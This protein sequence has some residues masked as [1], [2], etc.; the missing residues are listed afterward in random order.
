MPCAGLDC[1]F[2]WTLGSRTAMV[3]LSAF[4]KVYLKLKIISRGAL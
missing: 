2:K 4:L 3:H 1:R